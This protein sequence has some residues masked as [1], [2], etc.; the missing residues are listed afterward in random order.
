MLNDFVGGR[1]RRGE[2]KIVNDGVISISHWHRFEDVLEAR[3]ISEPLSKCLHNGLI[4]SFRGMPK[5]IHGSVI[6]DGS[7]RLIAPKSRQTSS[8]LWFNLIGLVPERVTIDVGN[9][10]I[11]K[12]LHRAGL[13]GYFNHVP[14]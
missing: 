10:E 3:D 4:V 2:N 14:I 11:E 9:R 8:L 12:N 5:K 7:P 6:G 1:V 13:S